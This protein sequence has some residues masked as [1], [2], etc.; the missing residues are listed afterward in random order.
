MEQKVIKP[1]LYFYYERRITL[2]EIELYAPDTVEKVFK[3]AGKAGLRQSGPLEF[4]YLRSNRNPDSPF[5]LQIALPVEK[6]KKVSSGLFKKSK[7]LKSLSYIQKGSIQNFCNAYESIFENIW[8]N[9]IKVT[10]ET[11]EV[12]HLYKG[13]D[14]EENVTEIQIG[15]L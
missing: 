12:Y 2:K 15:L 1:I 11:R 7:S 5:T 8:D 9:S 13:R 14:S 4:I 6:Q 3:E 10:N